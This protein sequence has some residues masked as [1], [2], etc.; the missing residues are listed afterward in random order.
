[1]IYSLYVTN[2]NDPSWSTVAT[3]EA[4]TLT[5]AVAILVEHN[6]GLEA[7]EFIPEQHIDVMALKTDII[8]AVQNLLDTTAQSRGYDGIV[9]L[10]TYISSHVPNFQTEAQAGVNWRDACWASCYQIM[11]DVE[12]GKRALPT[13]EEVLATLPPM[14][15]T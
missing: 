8:N 2:P 12:A 4:G 1:M 15:W 14:T 7:V 6:P 11:S 3:I 13:V 9:S 5:D 10:C